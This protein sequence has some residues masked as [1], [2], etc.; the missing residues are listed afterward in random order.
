MVMIEKIVEEGYNIVSKDKCYGK[1]ESRDLEIFN[2][3]I[4]KV[5]QGKILELGCG[6]CN[7]VGKKERE[8][9]KIFD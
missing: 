6:S 3:F 1:G 9:L 7:E 4:K 5:T 2:I 8:D